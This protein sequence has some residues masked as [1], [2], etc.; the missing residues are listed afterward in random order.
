MY[1]LDTNIVSELRKSRP[2]PAV[3]TWLKSMKDK[4]LFI[5]ALTLGELQ[6]G[7][8]LTR[9]QDPL[10]ADEIE[11]WINQLE[12]THQVL[13]M[14]ADIFREWARIMHGKSNEL[15]EDAMIAATARIHQF[16]VVTRNTKD[17]ERFDVAVINPF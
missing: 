2:H 3:V 8:E 4:H 17:F 11:N 14:T 6:A 7:V 13:P 12:Q 9:Q 1:L 10:K 5:S 15:I 16:K